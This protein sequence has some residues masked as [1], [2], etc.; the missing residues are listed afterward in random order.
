MDQPRKLLFVFG[1]RPEAIKLAP[2]IRLAKQK[3]EQF[4]S[5]VAVTAQHREMLDDVL[6]AF[7][8]APDADLDLMRPGQSL[9]YLT[10]SIVRAM[11][12][13]L[14]RFDPDVVVVQGDTTTAFAAALAGFYARKSTA[15]VEAGLRTG[16][17]T[18]PFP[19]EINRRL[20]SGI[21]DF[22][23]APTDSARQNLLK[24]GIPDAAI[25]VTGNTV[26]DSLMGVLEQYP[27]D[28]PCP[29]CSTSPLLTDIFNN[30]QK[31]VLVT[32]HR[33]ENFGRPFQ[34]LWTALA[35]AAR[36]HPETAFVYPIHPNPNVTNP[37][38][39]ILKNLPNF[40]LPPPLPYPAFCWSMARS[41]FIVTDSGGIQ[42][43][44]PAL[45]KPVLVTRQVTERPEAVAAGVVRLVG[46]DPAALG[47]WIQK[48]LND[49]S[50]YKKMARGV[51]P[52]GDGCAA[53]RILAV[54]GF[55]FTLA[56]FGP[57]PESP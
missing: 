50:C 23:F 44:A 46:D 40:F 13:V 7:D 4:D 52:Y 31:V 45:G 26:I 29:E 42:E 54:L 15:H 49:P 2:V 48:L 43:E 16:D 27:A 1:T 25:H 57:L 5:K 3:P 34:A 56:G 37:A 33:R 14:T 10:S 47:Q 35:K 19:E 24:E 20:I 51:S 30:Y 11:E 36:N 22:H 41:H 28:S 18:M 9:F 12:D 53:G 39:L 55:E 38:R 32:G 6:D 21:A 17:K 8:I